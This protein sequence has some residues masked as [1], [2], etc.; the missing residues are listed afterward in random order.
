[1]S[2]DYAQFTMSSTQLQTQGSRG[3]AKEKIIKQIP[4]VIHILLSRLIATAREAGMN[5]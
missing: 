2:R 4:F 5:S 1:M 3:N